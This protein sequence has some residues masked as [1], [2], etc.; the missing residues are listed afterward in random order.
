[1]PINEGSY[2]YPRCVQVTDS[3][4]VVYYYSKDSLFIYDSKSCEL[5]YRVPIDYHSLHG[6]FF[7]NKDSIWVFG[8]T[9][10]GHKHPFY[11]LDI[12]GNVKKKVDIR[13]YVKTEDLKDF[14]QISDNNFIYNNKMF[15]SLYYYQEDGKNIH[16]R[17]HP[18]IG[19]YDLLKDSVAL[20]DKLYFPYIKEGIYYPINDYYMRYCPFFTINEK[21]DEII[22][23]FSYT[24]SYYVWNFKT[25]QV[26]L[27]NNAKSV[28]MDTIMPYNRPINRNDPEFYPYSK[29]IGI[30]FGMSYLKGQDVYIRNLMLPE[31][32]YRQENNVLAFIDGEKR[33]LGEVNSDDLKIEKNKIYFQ[34]WNNDSLVLAYN[35]IKNKLNVY[36][37]R[38]KFIPI[39]QIDYINKMKS[40]AKKSKEKE[41]YEVCRIMQNKQSIEKKDI[42]LYLKEMH[43]IN[44]STFSVIIINSQGC[45][46]CNDYLLNNFLNINKSV[47]F[48]IEKNPFY[49]LYVDKN[50]SRTEI[51]NNIL[52]EFVNFEQKLKIDTTALYEKFNPSNSFNPRLI[53]VKDKKIITDSIFMPDDLVNMSF[54]LIRFYKFETY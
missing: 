18:I 44:D 12:Y 29:T 43:N 47:F 26:K 35:Y 21:K 50:E 13:D 4:V 16:Y 28:L 2:S 9:K 24:S 54:S 39:K 8:E 37:G 52:S 53:L 3:F 42:L 14:V 6:L 32:E 15:F 45:P 48:N 31:N 30:F 51:K 49:L 41:D 33:Y 25:N 22:I 34:E 40:K 36:L 17:K 10:K 19:Y 11:L 38:L 20:N 23:S 46:G 1:M 5:K 27:F 7:I